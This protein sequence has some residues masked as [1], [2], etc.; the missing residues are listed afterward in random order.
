MTRASLVVVN[1]NTASDLRA[2]L[3]SAREKLGDAEVVVVDNGSTDGSV[4]MVREEFPWAPVFFFG[5]K[6]K[7]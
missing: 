5:K 7:V 4:E 1:Y 6:G 3:A 2:C